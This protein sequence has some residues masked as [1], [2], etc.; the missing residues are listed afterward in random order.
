MAIG[1]GVAP[2][3]LNPR[4][5]ITPAASVVPMLGF[6]EVVVYARSDHDGAPVSLYAVGADGAPR[7]L[8]PTPINCCATVSPDGTLVAFESPSADGKHVPGSA[9][10]GRTGPDCGCW[11]HPTAATFRR[12]CSCRTAAW[13]LS[14]EGRRTGSDEPF[15]HGP[16]CG[17]PIATATRIDGISDAPLAVSPDGTRILMALGPDA[18]KPG[19]FLVVNTDGSGQHPVGPQAVNVSDDPFWGPAAGCSR[20]G[21]QITFST[22]PGGKR[23]TYVAN[24]DGSDVT[25]IGSSLTRRPLVA[26]AGVPGD[27]SPTRQ[28]QRDRDRSA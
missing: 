14:L 28:R 26:G 15:D 10:S 8:S 27:R 3:S 7:L 24:A 11:L 25:S 12:V 16:D 13:P 1:L 2:A 9:L 20:D 18:S 19:Q 22:G 17:D 6:D 4:A 21:T 5:I 23:T